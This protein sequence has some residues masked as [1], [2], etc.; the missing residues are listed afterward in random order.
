MLADNKR[1]H[2]G[3]T[4]VQDE[5]ALK[6]VVFMMV[7][8]FLSFF[9]DGYFPLGSERGRRNLPMGRVRWVWGGSLVKGS[10]AEQMLAATGALIPV[11]G[12]SV[13]KLHRTVA[14]HDK[15]QVEWR[16]KKRENSHPTF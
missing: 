12:F 6:E 4:L 2:N 5:S 3:I 15:K 14:T 13:S 11:G 16:K 7:L 8:S 10:T 9:L 1:P